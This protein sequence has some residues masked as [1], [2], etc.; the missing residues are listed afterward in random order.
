MNPEKPLRWEQLE[1]AESSLPIVVNDAVSRGGV[2]VWPQCSYT[3]VNVELQGHV[4][5]H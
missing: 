4:V 1:K 2:L 5:A 3:A